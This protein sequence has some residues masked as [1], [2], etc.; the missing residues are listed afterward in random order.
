[1]SSL[2][3]RIAHGEALVALLEEK[4]GCMMACCIC[5]SIIAA[6]MAACPCC[7]GYRFETDHALLVA[8]IRI[9][10]SRPESSVK[11]GDLSA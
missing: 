10:S 1:M 2:A 7:N 5:D 11:P 9:I 8:H 6:G 4:P 3:D